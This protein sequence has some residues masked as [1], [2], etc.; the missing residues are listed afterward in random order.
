M[1]GVLYLTFDDGPDPKITP[2]VLAELSK[3]GVL[4]TFFQVGQRVARYPELTSQVHAAGHLVGNHSWSH[5]RLD[6]IGETEVRG[7]LSNTS[8]AIE[9][10]TGSR[11][12][13]FR[14]PWGEMG[15]TATKRIG[16]AKEAS[17]LG[18]RTV[19]W[20]VDSQDYKHL[21]VQRIV[22]NV[23]D[24]AQDGAVLLLHDNLA[25]AAAAIGLILDEF[26]V[27]GYRFELWPDRD[28]YD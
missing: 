26:L 12:R 15:A 11:P 6:L 24:K 9:R 18:M 5:A 1:A 4:A 27:L 10:A 3:R 19:K 23:V 13:V 22:S 16:L 2:R 28:L 14:P 7:E 20:H 17:A 8:D 21:P 25:E